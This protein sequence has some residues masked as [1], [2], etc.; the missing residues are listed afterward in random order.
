MSAWPQRFYDGAEA[1]EL[2]APY[3]EACDVVIWYPRSACPRCLSTELDERKLAGR[4]RVVSWAVVHRSQ[5]E[6]LQAEAPY[7]IG[8][9]E[10]EE[11]PRLVAWIAEGAGTGDVVAVSFRDIAGRALPVFA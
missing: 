9:V 7:R 5:V 1:G 11:G 3:C 8:L 2:V 4:G 10:L 6:E